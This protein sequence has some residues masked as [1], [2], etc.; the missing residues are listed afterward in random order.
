MV[1]ELINSR[2]DKVH[3]CWLF[4]AVDKCNTTWTNTLNVK[5]DVVPIIA[6]QKTSNELSYKVLQV[7]MS[8][9][10][11]SKLSL[12]SKANICAVER[13]SSVEPDDN[14]FMWAPSNSRIL[15]WLCKCKKRIET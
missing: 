13:I 9:S 12:S 2:Y 10:S 11:S 1:I 5:Q 8:S 6:C 15:L 4:L 3:I 14:P 7:K